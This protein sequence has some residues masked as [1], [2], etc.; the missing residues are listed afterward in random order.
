MAAR[1]PTSGRVS[2]R[3]CVLRLSVSASCVSCV[4]PREADESPEAG[5]GQPD[6][7][8][9]GARGPRAWDRPG[10]ARTVHAGSWPLLAG[11]TQHAAS[12]SIRLAG[13]TKHAAS[14]NT[15]LARRTQHAGSANIRLAGRTQHAGS[16]LLRLRSRTVRP[17]SAGVRPGAAPALPGSHRGRL[18]GRNVRL[19][20][21]SERFPGE[22]SEK[23]MQLSRKCSEKHLV[24]VDAPDGVSAPGPGAKNPTSNRLLSQQP[25]G[26]HEQALQPGDRVRDPPPH[27][28]GLFS[29][30]PGRTTA[31]ATA[32]SD[33][34]ASAA[35]ADPPAEPEQLRVEPGCPLPQDRPAHPIAAGPSQSAVRLEGAAAGIRG[36]RSPSA[37]RPG[38]QERVR[39][40]AGRAAVPPVCGLAVLRHQRPAAQPAAAI[41][42]PQS[43]D[44]PDVR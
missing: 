29:A 35:A 5:P 27:A 7:F 3:P 24:L 44:L 40:T 34:G 31:G 6:R 11:R 32:E 28:T 18:A 30:G 33:N 37:L 17:G 26:V 41:D 10:P 4:S 9:I 1:N 22:S 12:A 39:S 42:A 25:G 13:R 20:A 23:E 8:E 16:A 2:V 15:R 38:V 43:R 36:P 21:A 14:A 19:S